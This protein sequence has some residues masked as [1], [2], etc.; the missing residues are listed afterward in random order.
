[1]ADL[2]LLVLELGLAEFGAA[3]E[4]EEADEVADDD[5]VGVETHSGP[6]FELLE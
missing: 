5:G 4:D 3:E 2:G 1:M 6:K